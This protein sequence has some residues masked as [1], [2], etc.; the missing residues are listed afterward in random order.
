MALCRQDPDPRARRRHYNPA[1]ELVTKQQLDKHD[2]Q[3]KY[4]C[5][6]VL[7]VPVISRQPRKNMQN[8]AL[9]S[10]YK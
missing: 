8:L 10:K 6:P 2:E 4:T 1:A 3:A 9:T 7:C 5:T